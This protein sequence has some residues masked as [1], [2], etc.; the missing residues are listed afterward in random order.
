MIQL[1]FHNFSTTGILRFYAS[2]FGFY[3]LRKAE[4]K[5]KSF[6]KEL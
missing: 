4:R 5:K 1:H 6:Y 3:D 2:Y